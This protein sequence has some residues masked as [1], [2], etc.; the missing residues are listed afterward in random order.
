[1]SPAGLHTAST[2]LLVARNA[3]PVHFPIPDPSKPLRAS[4]VLS[5]GTPVLAPPFLPL[6]RGDVGSDLEGMQHWPGSSVN[7][8]KFSKDCT[9]RSLIFM[10]CAIVAMSMPNFS[11]VAHPEIV[12]DSPV[13]AVVVMLAHA[14]VHTARD[15]QSSS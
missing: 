7:S 14:D 11:R 12:P 4:P 15:V 6:G 9:E 13:H 10:R 3:S 1:M 8:W 2:P 5:Q